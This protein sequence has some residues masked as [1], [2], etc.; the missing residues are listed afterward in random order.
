MEISLEQ[1][2]LYTYIPKRW[3]ALKEGCRSSPT[4]KSGVLT[5]DWQV[6]RELCR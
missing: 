1:Q 3:G 5:P 4:V 2:D 6:P